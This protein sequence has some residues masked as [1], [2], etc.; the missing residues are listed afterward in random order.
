MEIRGT[1]FVY[2]GWSYLAISAQLPPKFAFVAIGKNQKCHIQLMSNLK[3]LGTA[4]EAVD[5]AKASL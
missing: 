5:F 1:F 2:W 4:I 3:A